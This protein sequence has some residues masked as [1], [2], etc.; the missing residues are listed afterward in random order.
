MVVVLL[1]VGV[2][3]LTAVAKVTPAVLVLMLAATITVESVCASQSHWMASPSALV[4]VFKLI[5]SVT[6]P[7]LAVLVVLEVLDVVV[8]VVLVVLEVLDVVMVLV[9]VLVM[10][11]VL[12]VVIV[13]VV[14]VVVHLSTKSKF[15]MLVIFMTVHS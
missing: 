13:V 15:V 8:V 12:E 1:V 9:V 4:L 5:S 10:L 14:V 2:A 6:L 11:V 3:L 7:L